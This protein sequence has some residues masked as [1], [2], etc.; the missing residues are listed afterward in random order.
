MYDATFLTGLEN[1]PMTMTDGY[2]KKK[3]SPLFSSLRI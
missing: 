2:T 1:L 3:W